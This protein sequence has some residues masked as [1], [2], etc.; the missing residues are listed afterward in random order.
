[1]CG[2]AGLWRLAADLSGDALDAAVGA[3]ADALVHRGPDSSGVWSDP[4]AGLALGHRRLAIIDLSAAGHQPM[5][6][7]DG[8]FVIAYNGE[9]YNFAALR[10]ELESAGVVFRGGSDTEVILAACAAWGVERAVRRFVGMF[11]FALWD[12]RERR[13]HLVRDRLGIKPLFWSL[14]DGLLLFGSELKALRAH[15]ACPSVPRR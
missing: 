10:E 6:S 15:P 11:A 5:A 12:A 4:A 3:M 1:M 2:V 8:R 9:V 14:R 13:L 7:G